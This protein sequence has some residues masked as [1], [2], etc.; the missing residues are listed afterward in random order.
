MSDRARAVR[1]AVSLLKA[2]AVLVIVV[3]TVGLLVVFAS[4]VMD[5]G[6]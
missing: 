3:V 6:R 2:L 1:R 4:A 5:L